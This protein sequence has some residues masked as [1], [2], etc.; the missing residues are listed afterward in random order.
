MPDFDSRPLLTTPTVTLWD[1]ACAGTCRH[2]SP[3]ECASATHLVFPYRGI[4]IRNVGR[5]ETVAEAN[6]VLFFNEDEPYQ[7]SHPVAGG[8]SSLSIRIS[9]PTLLELTPPEHLHRKHRPTFNRPRLRLDTSTQARLARLRHRLRRGL[10]DTIEAETVTLTALR[11]ALGERT[12]RAAT[13]SIGRRKLADRAKL[14]LS[15]DPQRRW[16]LAEIAVNV[17]VSPVYLTQVF[18]Q[19]EGLPLYRYHLQLRLTR[20]LD[21]LGHQSD[22]TGLAL[23]LGFSSYSHFSAAFKQAY[24]GQTPRGFQRAARIR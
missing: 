14:V 1:V 15:S 13:S 7:V 18:Q 2:K 11:H 5:A 10:I 19:V 4:Y 21:L 23:D 17:G 16:T 22:L 6:Q 12:A 20:A 24:D 3:E 9:T 8:D